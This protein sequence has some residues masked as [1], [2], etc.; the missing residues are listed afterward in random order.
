VANDYGMPTN[1]KLVVVVLF[2]LAVSFAPSRS[3]AKDEKLKPEEL[4][5]KHLDSIGPAA[6]RMAARSR[7]TAGSAQ[8]IFRVGGSGSLNGK[9]NILSDGNSVRTGFT[10]PALDYSGEQLAFDGSKVTAGQISP[11]NYP[12]FARF[13]YEHDLLMKEGLLFGALSTGWALNDTPSRRPKLDVTGIKKVD[14]RQLYELKYGP[15]SVKDNMQVWLYFDPETF[16]HVR[17]QF[18]LE[19]PTS[20]IS[21]ISD[22]AEMVRYQIIEEFDQFKDVDGLMLPHSY[23]IDY[24]MDAPR[25]GIFSTWMH[26]ID[27]IT[28][29]ESIER[30]L[31]TL[32]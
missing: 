23:K 4:I 20:Q 17:S 19:V 18:R 22:S 15:R 16:R 25:G 28:H 21:R 8:V 6:K 14:G 5:A 10:F 3:T 29:N 13:V 31:F 9:G 24:T 11:G 26:Q 32:P 1:Q 7:K 27:R 12:P 30:R 2:L